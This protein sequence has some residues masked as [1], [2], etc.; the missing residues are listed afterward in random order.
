MSNTVKRFKKYNEDYD[1][2]KSTSYDHRQ[3][4]T[5]KRLQAALRSKVKS[6]LLTLIDDED[7]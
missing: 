7:Y 2:S 5:E 6:N 3:H 4:L 1:D